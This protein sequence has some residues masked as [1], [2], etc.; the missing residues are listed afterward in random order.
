MFQNTIPIPMPIRFCNPHEQRIAG[1]WF[2]IGRHRIRRLVDAKTNLEK[3]VSSTDEIDRRAHWLLAVAF[4]QSAVDCTRDPWKQSPWQA[5]RHDIAHVM[6]HTASQECVNATGATTT[7]DGAQPIIRY[8]ESPNAVLTNDL[9]WYIREVRATGGKAIL[10]CRRA[11]FEQWEKT[12]VEIT[13]RIW[14]DDPIDESDPFLARPL[15]LSYNEPHPHS[16]LILP[17]GFGDAWG[18][19]LELFDTNDQI[20]QDWLIDEWI[21]WR[22]AQEKHAGWRRSRSA[23]NWK[24]VCKS[25]G[26]RYGWR[27]KVPIC[28]ALEIESELHCEQIANSD[29]Y[30][31]P[32]VEEYIRDF[33]PNRLK[34]E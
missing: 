21:V 12:M 19:F 22:Y 23:R 18:G 29:G 3:C 8:Y 33:L 15:I 4:F 7:F 28:E 20:I 17:D 6:G 1:S 31:A 10:G 5:V 13:A 16:A 11:Q 27:R 9:G 26:E 32:F 14:C 2:H 25:H 30:L 34:S 24:P